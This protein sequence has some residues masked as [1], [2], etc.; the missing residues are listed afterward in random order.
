MLLLK[1]E[2]E[3]TK[4]ECIEK[5]DELRANLNEKIIVKNKEIAK[6]AEKIKQET[7]ELLKKN[8]DRV[9]AI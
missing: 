6:F 2:I 9:V 4:E 7:E 1:N 3:K 5:E 8:K